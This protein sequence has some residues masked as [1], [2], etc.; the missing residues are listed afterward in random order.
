MPETPPGELRR[1]R[2]AAE[3]R[4]ADLESRL[5]AAEAQ[6]AVFQKKN[7]HRERL[8]NVPRSPQGNALPKQISQVTTL[9]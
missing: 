3:K 2:N 7:E 6:N 8:F 4:G 5:N 1:Q 9:E